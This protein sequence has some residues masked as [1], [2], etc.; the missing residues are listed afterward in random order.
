[1]RKR[2]L[3]KHQ[4]DWA[5]IDVT[6]GCFKVSGHSVYTAYMD[7]SSYSVHCAIT[8]DDDDTLNAFCTYP[9]GWIGEG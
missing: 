4:S 3:G 2:V 1:M 5:A 9:Q 8:D 7:C 6:D